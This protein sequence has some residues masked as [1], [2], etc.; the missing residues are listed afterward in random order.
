MVVSGHWSQ[1]V[2][3]V[4]NPG[5]KS[6][7]MMCQQQSRLNY[8]RKVYTAHTRMYLE[9]SAWVIRKLFHWTLQNTY[10]IKPLYQA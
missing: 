6:L 9:C 10:S 2:L 5:G 7:P 8:N 4:G 1:P 3:I